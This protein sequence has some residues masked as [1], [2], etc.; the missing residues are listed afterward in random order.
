MQNK[1][2]RIVQGVSTRLLYT[3]TL[4]KNM[5]WLP[6][7]KLIEYRIACLIHQ[8]IYTKKPEYLHDML[9]TNN[10]INICNNLGNKLG[11]KPGNIGSS[12]FTKDQFCSHSYDIYN[13]IP[14]IITSIKNKLTFKKYL[15][16]YHMNNSD[17]PHSSSFHIAG[18]LPGI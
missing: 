11:T 1:A 12:Q 3:T 5:N 8:I 10:K 17:L 13:K 6:I 14:S 7:D 15:K 18:L 16:R 2:T 4:I 9:I